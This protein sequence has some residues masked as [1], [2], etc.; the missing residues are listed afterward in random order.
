MADVA[1]QFLGSGDAFGSGARDQTCIYVDC[2]DF[3][4]L[5]DKK[6]N[7]HMDYATLMRHRPELGCRHLDRSCG[8]RYRRK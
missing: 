2:P 1:V 7:F 6:I 8:V 4:F 3:R 5:I